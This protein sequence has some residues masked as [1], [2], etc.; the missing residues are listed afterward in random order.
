MAYLSRYG[1][2]TYPTVSCNLVYQ[3]LCRIISFYWIENTYSIA[4]PRNCNNDVNTN[5]VQFLRNCTRWKNDMRCNFKL[6]SLCNGP[7]VLIPIFPVGLLNWCQTGCLHENPGLNNC[8]W[9]IAKFKNCKSLVI[10]D[11]QGIAINRLKVLAFAN[12]QA[13]G[14]THE[15]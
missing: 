4:I 10:S 14:L 6:V 11:Y 9:G 3:S 15:W 7:R 12:Y 8:S 13:F 2:K 5:V 1:A